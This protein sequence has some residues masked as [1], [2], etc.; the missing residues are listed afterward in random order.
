M[1]SAIGCPAPSTAIGHVSPPGAAP[2]VCLV[3]AIVPLQ[4]RLDGFVSTVVVPAVTSIV[5]PEP[6]STPK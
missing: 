2:T 6:P 4:R 5:W 3:T 1:R